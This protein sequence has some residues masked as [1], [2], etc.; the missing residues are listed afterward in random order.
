MLFISK[1]VQL[2]VRRRRVRQLFD[3]AVG[4]R[5]MAS[6]LLCL[7]TESDGTVQ[8]EKR[9]RSGHVEKR[10]VVGRCSNKIAVPE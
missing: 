3:F 6:D 1:A 5:R 7:N 9:R 2:R 10:C 8:H 4:E